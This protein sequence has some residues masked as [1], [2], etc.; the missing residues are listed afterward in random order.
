MPYPEFFVRGPQTYF[1]THKKLSKEYSISRYRADGFG[2]N[3]RV[4]VAPTGAH[5]GPTGA[6][7]RGRAHRTHPGAHQGTGAT[8]LLDKRHKIM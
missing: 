2:Q 6:G 1:F 8:G 7:A 4:P 3:G 5:H